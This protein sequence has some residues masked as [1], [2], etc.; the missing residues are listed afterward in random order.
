MHAA[1]KGI[2]TSCEIAGWEV[3][4]SK[5]QLKW[6][7]QCDRFCTLS[8]FLAKRARANVR[9][10]GTCAPCRDRDNT[11]RARSR[12][13]EKD[14]RILKESDAANKQNV[15]LSTGASSPSLKRLKLMEQSH[16]T[17]GVE[18]S[19]AASTALVQAKPLSVVSVVAKEEG[20]TSAANFVDMTI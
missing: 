5:L 3:V 10:L 20:N 14:A 2:C 15:K 13:R 16:V 8:S 9:L 4:E 17:R 11:N 18:L 7:R 19:A 1:S 6:C 12:K